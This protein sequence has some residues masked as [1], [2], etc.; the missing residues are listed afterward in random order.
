LSERSKKA[1]ELLETGKSRGQVTEACIASD[2]M[3]LQRIVT[4]SDDIRRIFKIDG[5]DP[6]KNDPTHDFDKI[7]TVNDFRTLSSHEA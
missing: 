6:A 4:I 5:V 1:V 7:E 3:M 2:V